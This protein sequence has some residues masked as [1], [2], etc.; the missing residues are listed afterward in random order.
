MV[1]T[2]TTKIQKTVKKIKRQI[3]NQQTFL[4]DI[5]DKGLQRVMLNQPGKEHP[6]R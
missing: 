2:V 1:K 3:K 4:H 5:F 6:N